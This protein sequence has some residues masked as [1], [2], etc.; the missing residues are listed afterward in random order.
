MRPSPA[1]T[2][3]DLYLA[4]RQAKTALY[5][6]KRGV[7]LLELAAY[8][9]ELPKNLKLLQGKLAKGKWF[10]KLEIGETWIVPKRLRASQGADD[11]VV[12]IGASRQQAA[13]RPIDIQLRLS[14]H[15]EF[16]IVEV[17]YLWRFGGVL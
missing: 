5:F 15:P 4:F 9:Q 1:P 7:G 13:G 11:G 12:R 14:P 6:E 3:A 17:M 16:A 10:D 2:I 8:E